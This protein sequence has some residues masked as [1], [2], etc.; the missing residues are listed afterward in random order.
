MSHS[1]PSRQLLRAGRAIWLALLATASFALVV[2]TAGAAVIT[3]TGTDPVDV[4]DPKFD[5][6]AGKLVY[7]SS[8]GKVTVSA[9]TV[10]SSA[11]VVPMDVFVLV[12]RTADGACVPDSGASS[13]LAITLLWH[14]GI[15]FTKWT[16]VDSG[17]PPGDAA[18]TRTGTSITTSAGPADIL[19]DKPFDCAQIL[20]KTLDENEQTVDVDAV[21]VSTTG[22]AASGPDKDRDGVTD[23]ADKCP[24]VPGGDR[25][26][27]LTIP[28]KLAVRLGAKRVAIDKLVPRTGSTCPIKAKVT[29][30]SGRK[31]LGKGVISVTSHGSFC[32]AYGVVKLKKTAKKAKI[33]VKA[34]GMG[35]ISASRKR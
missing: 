12:G 6:T 22:S 34:T 2:P 27:C 33:T 8:A 28:A 3:M 11:G 10:A 29:V 14:K 32:R 17:Q 13:V 35:S 18:S 26:G 7:D 21:V 5:L 24:T 19:K 25:Y 15:D 31:T 16:L 1:L 20:T 9:Q 30:K 4:K 23:A